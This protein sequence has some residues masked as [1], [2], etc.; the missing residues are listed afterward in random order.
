MRAKLGIVAGGGEL[1]ARLIA[2]CQSNGRDTFV[3]GLK[4]QADANGFSDP[5][6]AWIRLGEVG[7]GLNLLRNAGVREL[8]IAGKVR[9]PSLAA[10]RPDPW[11][12]K[13]LVMLGIKALGDDSLMSALVRAIEEEGFTIVPPE[14]LVD[15]LL[16][17]ERQYGAVAPDADGVANIER[18]VQAA[19]AI[20]ALDIG[21]AAIVQ[22]GYVLGL[23]A[24]EGTDGLIRRCA[25]L[26]LK[27]SG[28][29]LVKLAKPDQ[30]RR[31]D[32]PTIGVHTVAAAA[33]SGLAGIALEAGG[34][35]IV[36]PDATIRAADEADLFIVGIRVQA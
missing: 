33:E 26:R 29:V 18:G 24:A 25:E 23:E 30:E 7:K 20:G 32:L 28:G 16:V 27:G 10:L 31:V 5:P 2:A 4:G 8:V 19:K 6:D 12:A 9:R 34:A 3:I 13:R 22:Q 11:T 1:P 21:Q 35:L 17:A 15:N 36:D 14:N